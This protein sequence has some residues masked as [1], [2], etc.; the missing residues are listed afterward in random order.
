M[1]IIAN[2]SLSMLTNSIVTD[3]IVCEHT[4]CIESVMLKSQP[5]SNVNYI[6]TD[7]YY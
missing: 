1:T 5:I 6:I 2:S 7:G 3:N 4:I